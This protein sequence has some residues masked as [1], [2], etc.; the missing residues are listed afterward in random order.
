MLKYLITFFGF[1]FL[2]FKK[3]SLIFFWFLDFWF[4]WIIWIF[5][6][7]FSLVIL[8]LS[9]DPL[10]LGAHRVRHVCANPVPVVTVAGK[11]RLNCFLLQR[12][13]FKFLTK[14]NFLGAI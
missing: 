13:F 8:N 6:W 2:A 11:P 1:S 12:I 14:I 10:V 7:I 9:V 5:R 3:I 4:F